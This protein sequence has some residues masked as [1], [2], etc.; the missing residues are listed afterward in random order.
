[1]KLQS[2]IAV[3]LALLIGCSKDEA[4]DNNSL[5]LPSHFPEPH[6]NFVNN[7][8]TYEGFFLGRKLFYDPILSVNN[9]VSCGTCHAPNHAF[10]DHNM[11]VSFGVFG[12]RGTR[13]SPP[14]FNLLWSTS[15][16]WDGGVNHIE[17]SG[18]PAITD[19][20][21]MAE[22]IGN[23]VEKLKNHPKYPEWFKKAFG[24][25]E[26]TDQLMFYALTQFMGAIIS[27]ES[28]YDKYVTGKGNL[29]QIELDGL[30]L[31]RTHCSACHTEPLFTDYSFRNNGL[32]EEF[33]DLG[34]ARI[35]LDNND[36]G[37]FKVPT[38]RNVELTYPYMHDGRFANLDEVLNHYSSGI[39]HSPTLDPL[40][41]G[42]IVLS[43]SDKAKLKA[44]LL[45]LTD[46][47]LISNLKF[48]EQ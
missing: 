16:M 32:D 11:P 28:K 36:N 31:F 21:E 30:H 9:T 6:Y 1:M 24:N 20:N 15:F 8:I 13:N 40:L 46:D 23:V 39:V 45:T 5:V 25:V 41:S 12:R 29:S 17:V 34:R 7:P 33:E 38:L 42:G 37:K 44:F 19:E 35:S 14:V 2:I 10:A 3:L 43:E 18:F 47:A 26:I 22:D 48:Y 4:P 27:S